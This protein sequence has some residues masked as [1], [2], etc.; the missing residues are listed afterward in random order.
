MSLEEC[1]RA[2]LELS[3]QI[4]TPARTQA[5]FFAR[6]KDLVLL[7]GKFDKHKFESAIKEL[8]GKYSTAGKGDLLKTS[9]ES[10]KVYVPLFLC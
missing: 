9:D 3:K 8:V 4:F 6:S 2:Y 5:N 1:S 7:N 10:C